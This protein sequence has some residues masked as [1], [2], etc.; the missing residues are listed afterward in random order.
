MRGMSRRGLM[1]GL[2]RVR[3]IRQSPRWDQSPPGSG[4]RLSWA[5]TG[6]RGWWSSCTGQW[7]RGGRLGLLGHMRLFFVRIYGLFACFSTLFSVQGETTVVSE[8]EQPM[9]WFA[10]S[11][12][13]LI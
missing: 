11:S 6:S 10:H 1:K 2:C 9:N 4:K 5:F 7:G 12:S 3:L 13:W 8:A